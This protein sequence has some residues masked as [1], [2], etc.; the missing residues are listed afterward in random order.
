RC[1]GMGAVPAGVTRAVPAPDVAARELAHEATRASRERL[2]AGVAPVCATHSGGA[3]ARP[4]RPYEPAISLIRILHEG[5]CRSLGDGEI[6]PLRP[7][8]YVDMTRF[9]QAL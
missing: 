7:G 6:G 2:T 1:L 5:G 8:F 4:I 3:R 9:C